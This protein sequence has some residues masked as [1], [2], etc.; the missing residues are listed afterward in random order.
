MPYNPPA[1]VGEL[2]ARRASSGRRSQSDR[3]RKQAR[4]QR[5]VGIGHVEVNQ[6]RVPGRHLRGERRHGLRHPVVRHDVIRRREEQPDLAGDV[7]AQAIGDEVAPGRTEVGQRVDR[8]DADKVGPLSPSVGHLRRIGEVDQ[9]IRGRHR[10]DRGLHQ[11]QGDQ[12]EIER[13]VPETGRDRRA[14]RSLGLR[15]ISRCPCL[16]RGDRGCGRQQGHCTGE[17]A[18]Q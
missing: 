11:L 2:G 5:R 4:D 1:R 18:Y 6:S 17:T 3:V 7:A 16:G 14:L 13:W 9:P 12:G 10:L 15:V 8:H